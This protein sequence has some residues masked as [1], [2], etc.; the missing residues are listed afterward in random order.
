MNHRAP[1]FVGREKELAALARH[2]RDA[3]AGRGSVALI[4]GEPGI[5]KSR[6]AEE[7]AE[8]A[9]ACGIA[10]HWGLCEEGESAPAFWPWMQIVRGL[11]RSHDVDDVRSAMGPAAEDLDHLLPERR[12][13]VAPPTAPATT[14]EDHTRSRRFDSMCRFLAECAARTPLLLIVEDLQWATE[15]SLRL[16]LFVAGQLTAARVLLLLTCRDVGANRSPQLARVL[17]GLARLPGH[18]RM[19]LSGLSRT[20]VARVM[21]AMAGVA[22]PDNLLNSV[23]RRTDGNPFFV[24]ELVRSLDDADMWH[25]YAAGRPP[26]HPIP[27]TLRDVIQERLDRLSRTC[28]HVLTTAAA[29]GPEFDVALLAQVTSGR[30]HEAAERLLVTLAEAE[31]AAIIAGVV[32]VPGRFRFAHDLIREVL[33]AALPNSLKPTLH[34]HIGRGLEAYYGDDV[35]PHLEELAHHFFQAVP[36]GDGERAIAYAV[37][38]ARRAEQGLAPEVGAGFYNLALRV[39]DLFPAGDTDRRYELLMA[40]GSA[41]VRGGQLDRARTT[42]R[43]AADIARRRLP[44]HHDQAAEDLARAALGLQLT[45]LT[46][47]AVDQR[48]VDLIEEALARVGTSNQPLRARLL[49]RLAME[50]YYASDRQR[51]RDLSVQALQLARRSADAAALAYVLQARRYVAWGPDTVDERL[52][53]AGEMVDLA[54]TLGD[55]ELAMAG[56]HT[57]LVALQEAGDMATAI[58]ELEAHGR[59][60]DELRQ[61]YYQWHVMVF[62]AMRAALEGRFDDSEALAHQARGFGLRAEAP[63]AMQVFSLQMAHLRRA[64]G[65]LDEAEAEVRVALAQYPALPIWR[66]LSMALVCEAGRQTE[67]RSTLERYARDGFAGI[68]ADLFWLANIALLSEVCA[69]LGDADRAAALYGLLLPYAHLNVMCGRAACFGPVTR[70]LG[71]LAGCLGRWADA[72]RHFEDALAAGARMGARPLLART[73][74]DFAAML[75]RAHHDTGELARPRT[76][77][78]DRLTEREVMVL[79]LLADGQSNPEIAAALAISVKTVERHTVNIYA[80]IGA[81]NRVDATA[82]ALRHGLV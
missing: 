69:C 81:R 10:V 64:Q 70:Y 62:R 82:Y 79:R 27:A 42:F 80:K 19:A 51:S 58:A 75:R 56:Y 12:A 76:P 53:L 34:H 21:T 54:R 6:L 63:N 41:E 74:L 59:L 61:P 28:R 7:L 25:A 30:R 2:L 77:C 68:P 5:G 40:R 72:S 73:Q 31:R 46:T 36:V 47:G 29:L 9:R 24:A 49:G 48:Q 8:S 26:E 71:L 22:P 60:A 18:E 16:L 66:C 20:E 39:L 78:G 37:R 15:P 45:A 14:D 52:T 33:Y 67:A 57:R 1:P 55:P 11:A 44:A 43:D 35:E 32:G 38:A 23:Y 17:A 4:T 50:L 3:C 65:R 13:S